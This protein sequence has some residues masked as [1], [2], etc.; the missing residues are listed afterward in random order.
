MLQLIKDFFCVHIFYSL[1]IYEN[2]NKCNTLRNTFLLL[3]TN[4]S[5]QNHL[6]KC[7][8]VFLPGKKINK[9]MQ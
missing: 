4:F 9:G 3:T 5:Q 8:Q 1:F 2:G 6:K 7:V